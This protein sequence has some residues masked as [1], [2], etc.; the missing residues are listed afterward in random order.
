MIKLILTLSILFLLTSCLRTRSDIPYK[1]PG[2][3]SSG[4]PSQQKPYSASPSQKAYNAAPVATSSSASS[5]QQLARLQIGYQ[6]INAQMRSLNGRLEAVEQHLSK[7]SLSQANT[8]IDGQLKNYEE[9]LSSLEAEVQSLKKGLSSDALAKVK[10]APSKK[11]NAFERGEKKFSQQNW[12]GAISEYQLYRE[13]YPKGRN[14]AEATYKIG[15][16]FQE[17]TLK[18]E[19]KSFYQEAVQKYP[20]SKAAKKSKIRLKQL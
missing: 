19:A 6:E 5:A 10:T 9:A 8:S 13:Q 1:R 7:L 14:Y 18:S 2:Y 17:L 15:V 11:L 3:G 16:C 4:N 12:R 20:S